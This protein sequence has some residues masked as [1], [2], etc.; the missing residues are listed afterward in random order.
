LRRNIEDGLP[1]D[2]E[3]DAALVDVARGA[4]AYTRL[5]FSSK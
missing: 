2:V 3:D 1:E 4:R 5:L